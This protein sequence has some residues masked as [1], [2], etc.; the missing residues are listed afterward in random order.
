MNL[1]S[2]YIECKCGTEVL[3]LTYDNEDD[4]L[5]MALFEFGYAKNKVPLLQRLR[6]IWKILTTGVCWHDQLILDREESIK[7][8][9]YVKRSLDYK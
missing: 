5:Y 8:L 9:N 7:L 2:E 6:H 4:S 3:Q 1:K